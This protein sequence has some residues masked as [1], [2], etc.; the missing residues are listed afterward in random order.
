MRTIKALTKLYFLG[1][2]R[3]Q[4]H[5]AT[6]FI[7]VILLMLPAYIN[8]FSLGVNA[9]ER[10]TKDFGLTIIA[11]FG[12]G[13][14]LLL[15]S[16]SIPKD[17]ENRAIYPVLARPINRMEYILAHL[18]ATLILLLASVLFLGGCLSLALSAMTRTF[19][20]RFFLAI[21]ALFLQLSIV[22]SLTMAVSTVASPALAGTFGAFVYL[23]GSLPG[24]FIRFFLVEDRGG[25]FSASLATGLKSILP[26]LS[27][28]NLKDAIV[29]EIPLDPAYVP[30][31]IAYAFLWIALSLVLATTLFGKKDL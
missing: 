21:L 17:L 9:F 23:V 3:R 1:S 20:P 24:A 10:V 19:D 13:M 7:G 5:L 4:A 31:V 30:A 14:A 2:L 25:G 27:L 18:L 8:A 26:N 22:A 11:Y 29:H 15:A 16:T 12:V 6:L 28:F